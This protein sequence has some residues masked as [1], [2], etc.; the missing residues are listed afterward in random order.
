GGASRSQA[1]SM[2]TP[3]TA[4]TTD[5]VSTSAPTMSTTL[6]ETSAQANE[7]APSK[8]GLICARRLPACGVETL[9][10]VGMCYAGRRCR[11]SWCGGSEVRTVSLILQGF[12]SNHGENAPC[13]VKSLARD[14]QPDI[15]RRCPRCSQC[16]LL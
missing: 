1:K 14:S 11:P 4:R 16:W 10:T 15:G 13:C 3:R 2:A 6:L 7:E 12:F 5:M 8:A 9:F